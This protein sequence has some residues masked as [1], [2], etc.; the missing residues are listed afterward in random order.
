MVKAASKVLV[1]QLGQVLDLL[2]AA[3]EQFSFIE[4]NRIHVKTYK[5]EQGGDEEE[6][7]KAKNKTKVVEKLSKSEQKKKKMEEERELT[8]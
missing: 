4:E 1:A 3:S 5:E 2:N 8:A 6:G 7:E